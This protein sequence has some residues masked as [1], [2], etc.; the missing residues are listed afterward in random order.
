MRSDPP[1]SAGTIENVLDGTAYRPCALLGR[2][3]MGEVWAVRHEMIGRDFALKILHQRHLKNSQLIERIRFEARAMAALDH[4]NV[5]EVIDFW[6]SPD[7]RPC[8][9]MEMLTGQRLDREVLRRRRLPGSEVVQIGRQAL[10]ALAAAHGIGLVHRDIKPENLFLHQVRDSAPCLKLLDFG[11]ARVLGGSAT[12][13]SLQ[14][15]DLTRTGAVLGSP[16]FMSPEAL[17]G[18]RVGPAS[19]IY[20]L[21][22]VLYVCLLGLHSNFDLSTLPVFHPPS[23]LG[24]IDCSSRLDSVI[25]RAVEGDPSRRY[26]SATAFLSELEDPTE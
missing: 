15:L 16:R 19:D 25:L 11:L 26:P 1:L 13:G 2:G 17:R 5:V 18:E 24:A 7:G 9:V 23:R 6:V 4:P 21:G 22:V 3:S 8:L 12:G 10:S 20:S 14:P